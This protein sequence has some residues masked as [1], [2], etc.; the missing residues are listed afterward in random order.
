MKERG[1]TRV[2]GLLG[3]GFDTSDEK[4][5]ITQAERYQVLMGSGETHQELQKICRRIE[6]SIKTSGRVLS[7][8][9]PE[10]FMELV[11]ELY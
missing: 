1:Q 10:E 6:E 8:Y 9:T 11:Q 7:D 5:R 3:V 2:V 4:I